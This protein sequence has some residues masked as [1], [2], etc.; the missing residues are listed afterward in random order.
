ME[1]IQFQTAAE[2]AYSIISQ[3]ILDGEFKPGEKLSRRKMAQITGTSVIP[4]IEAMKRLEEDHLVESKPQWGAFVTNPTLDGVIE[5]YQMREALECEIARLASQK[6]SAK[7]KEELSEIARRLDNSKYAKDTYMDMREAHFQF[8][9]KLA[10]SSGNKMLV[11]SLHRINLFWI[12]CK[13]LLEKR[14]TAPSPRYWHQKLLD[15]IAQ[16]DPDRAELSMREHI[17]DSLD[18]IR[19]N[20]GK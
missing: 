17:H 6:M 14:P 10:E 13:A 15:I 2:M 20:W 9:T 12:L 11:K 19:T 18:A 3:K 4:V 5:M 7:Q 8:H 1:N 16:G